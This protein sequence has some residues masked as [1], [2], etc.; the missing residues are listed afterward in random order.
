MSE[1]WF[2]AFGSGAASQ[3]VKPDPGETAPTTEP[4]PWLDPK[5]IID[6]M[7]GIRS[8]LQRTGAALGAAATAVIGGLGYA[9][10][11]NIF[12][13]PKNVGWAAKLSLP[14]FFVAAVGGAI[15]LAAIFMLAQRRIL[16][17]TDASDDLEDSPKDIKVANRVRNEFA[18]QEQAKTLRDVQMRAVRLANVARALGPTDPARARFVQAESDRLY[19]VVNLALVKASA[20]IL[21][22]RSRRAFKSWRTLFALGFAAAGIIGVFAM[23]DHFKS[24]RDLFQSQEAC[25][26]AEA[27]GIPNACAAFES[28]KQTAARQKLASK[29]KAEAAAEADAA[30]KRLSV[31][32][33]TALSVAANCE[34][35]IDHL[36]PAERPSGEA[37][38]RVVRA[39]IAAR[40]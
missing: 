36:A 19:G 38:S 24:Q 7:D 40:S 23:S 16:I 27:N 1:R 34:G 5:W 14:L 21:E 31:P 18:S 26:K 37:R 25:A 11:H 30:F 32:Q 6:V 33:K 35:A 22:D 17:E 28:S 9:Q 8:L 29:V 39:C 10:L 13:I 3:P 2:M 20:L 15:W 4:I 12:P